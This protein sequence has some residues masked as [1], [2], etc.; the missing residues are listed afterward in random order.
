M[1]DIK[2]VDHSDEAKEAM[3][4]AV[5]AAL[6]AIG[7]QAV[8]Y[9]KSNITEAGRVDTGAMRNSVSHQVEGGERAVYVGTNQ[10][11]AAFHEMGTGIYLDGGGGRTTPWSYQDAKGNWHTTHGIQPIHFLRNAVQDH[12][13]E[14]IQLGGEIIKQHQP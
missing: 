5:L 4:E 1:A 9:A 10:E 2:L 12:Q 7:Q 11:Y 3:E 6:E 13:D 8:S 14:L